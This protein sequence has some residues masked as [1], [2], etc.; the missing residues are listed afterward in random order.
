MSAEQIRHR[1]QSI[2]QVKN[3]DAASRT[4][5]SAIFNA[6]H[7][8]RAMKTLYHAAGDDSHYT[9]M[10]AFARKH[11]CCVAIR[12][13]LFDA[14]LEDRASR[15]SLFK[16][17]NFAARVRATSLSS[18]RNISITSAALAMRPAALIRGAT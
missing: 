4:L 16:S 13:R 9:P 5:R 3:G 12:H 17:C 18:V 11:E 2:Q 7:K 8:N 14:L 6:Q 15:R 1:F 10:P